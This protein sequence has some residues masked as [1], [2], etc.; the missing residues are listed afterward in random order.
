MKNDISQKS[1]LDIYNQFGNSLK[2]I[3]FSGNIR[4][5]TYSGLSIYAAIIEKMEQ[6][7]RGRKSFIVNK[8]S[9]L[10]IKNENNRDDVEKASKSFLDEINSLYISKRK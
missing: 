3:S 7:E 4:M 6:E 2:V 9:N 10:S 1:V 8:T 5:M